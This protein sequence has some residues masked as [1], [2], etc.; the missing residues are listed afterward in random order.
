MAFTSQTFTLTLLHYLQRRARISRRST[1]A[2]GASSASGRL[3]VRAASR[4]SERSPPA[5]D[6]ADPVTTATL[7][8]VQAREYLSALLYCIVH[9]TEL[10]QCIAYPYTSVHCRVI[11]SAVNQYTLSYSLLTLF[12]YTRIRCFGVLIKSSLNEN[13]FLL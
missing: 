10:V 9:Y 13:T 7:G 12:G 11:V 1:S 2:P 4:S 6:F 5:G 3:H 8:I